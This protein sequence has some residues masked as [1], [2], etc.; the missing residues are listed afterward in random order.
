MWRIV[1]QDMLSKRSG[2]NIYGPRTSKGAIRHI[3]G[4]WCWRSLV[5]A[6]FFPHPAPCHTDRTALPTRRPLFR[7]GFPCVGRGRTAREW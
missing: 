7:V 1:F 5:P 6:G 3:L 2:E 4:S